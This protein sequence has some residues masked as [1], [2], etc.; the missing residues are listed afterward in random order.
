M[1]SYDGLKSQYLEILLTIFAFFRKMIPFK[2]TPSRPKSARA[3]PP[4][5]AYIVPD[6]IQIVHFRQRNWRMREDRFCP[7]EY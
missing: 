4:N 1:W 6:V 2:L 3:S 5:L 7:V